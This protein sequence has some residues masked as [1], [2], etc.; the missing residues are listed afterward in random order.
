MVQ[1]TVNNK[2]R[3]N[4]L[5][6]LKSSWPNLHTTSRNIQKE[7]QLETIEPQAEPHY[8]ECVNTSKSTCLVCI[9]MIWCYA[10]NES[11]C[12]YVC[13][14]TYRYISICMYLHPGES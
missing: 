6:C 4:K 12:M 2:G 11:M 14:D 1:V 7:G 3:I 9:M 10:S 8:V 13:I 5:L